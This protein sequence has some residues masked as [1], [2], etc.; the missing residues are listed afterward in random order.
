MTFFEGFLKNRDILRNKNQTE[1]KTISH[2]TDANKLLE[3]QRLVVRNA[4]ELLNV[5]T[6]NYIHMYLCLEYTDRERE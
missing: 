6:V 1:S 4:K 5:K 3:P 2:K